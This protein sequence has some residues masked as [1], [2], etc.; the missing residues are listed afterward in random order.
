MGCGGSKVDSQE[1]VALCRGRSDLLAD[2]IRYRYT[3]AAA[4]AAYSDSLLSLASSLHRFLSPVL[5]LPSHRKVD[6]PPSPPPPISVAGHS[7]SHSGSHIHFDDDDDDDDE[8]SSHHH[9]PHE[10]LPPDSFLNLYYA[11]SHPPPPSVS[12]EHRPDSSET[13][14]FGY[15]AAYPYYGAQNPNPVAYDPQPY[16]YFPYNYDGMGGGGGSSSPPLAAQLPRPPAASTGSSSSSSKAPPPPPSP[17]RT[18]TWDFLNPFD[19][20]D[21]YYAS[22]PPS[23]GSKEVRDEEGIPDLED[24][25]IEVVKEAYGDQK[26]VASTSAAA[27]LGTIGGRSSVADHSHGHKSGLGAAD[28]NPENEPQ[29]VDKKVVSRDVRGK[30]EEKRSVAAPQRFHDLSEIVAEIKAQFDRA[31]ESAR[32]LS[33]MLEVG[34]QP[35]YRNNS[36]FEVSSRMVWVMTPSSPKGGDLLEFDD[37]KL[38]GSGNLSSTLQKLY[39]WEMKLYDEVRA[40]EKMRL[41]LDRNCKRLKHLDEKGAEAHKIDATRSLIRKLSTKI[42]IAIQVIDSISNKINKLRDEEL[43]P[44]INELILGF[45]RMWKVMLECHQKQHQAILEAKSLDSIASGGKFGEAHI[46]SMMELEMELLKWISNFSTWINAQKNYVK[47]LNGWAALCLHYEPED[48]ADG[49]PPYSPGRVGAPPVFVICNCWS[50]A[51]DQIS[52]RE[53]LNSIHAFATTI[54]HLWEQHNVEQHQRMMARKDL[55]MWLKAVQKKTQEIHKEVDAL[56]KKLVLIPGQN[57]IPLYGE[58]HRGQTAEAS[59][60]QLVLRQFFEAM[61]NFTAT[62][63]KAYEQLH[64]HC[65]EE[66]LA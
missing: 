7:H 33:R 56:N 13:V 51:M 14:R 20:F 41:L 46:N 54:Q 47:A 48:T 53:V 26:F 25:E 2:A 8:A 31:S 6:T 42:R 5:P 11:R 55:D 64:K 49:I 21:R 65:E 24:D 58:V 45:E 59:S 22:Y 63:V 62:S 16:P 40:E 15:S 35:Y 3:L 9:L 39:I 61:E 34:K 19:S 18:S 23:R 28:D 44:Q 30:Q 29:L 43:W 10:T 50:Q 57:G 66:R 52:E 17:P 4:H 12:V 38:S 60:L 27:E 36:V 32:E 1:A 37:D